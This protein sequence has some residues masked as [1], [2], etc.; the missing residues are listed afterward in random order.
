MWGWLARI[1]GG[2]GG[3]TTGAPAGPP[4]P[5]AFG[6]NSS[7][8]AVRATDMRAVAGAL[9]LT[10]LRAASWAE[11][12]QE[13]S[14]LQRRRPA[15]FVT[16][17]VDGWVLAVLG[18]DIASD[19]GLGSAAL[20]LAALSGRFGEAQKLATQ[21]VVEY[22]EWQRWVDG[23]PVRRYC[24]IG[25]SGEIC[26]DEGARIPAEGN[27]AS[28]ADLEAIADDAELDP[29]YANEEL[30]MAVARAW[31]VDPTTLEERDDLPPD[32]LLGD[33]AAR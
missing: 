15:V 6:Y 8:L 3:G 28:A 26:F 27:V 29:N 13:T 4:G 5:R 1:F 30:V 11:G 22:H 10:D 12:L 14:D 18:V 20:D 33:V 7:W 17:P 21:H 9:G 25:E 2:G 31:S 24:Y 23:K 19:D 32:G 16:P